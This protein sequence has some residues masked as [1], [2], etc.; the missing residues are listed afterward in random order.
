MAYKIC[1]VAQEN[2]VQVH[3]Y[4]VPHIN[5]EP[6]CLSTDLK[7]KI[8]DV[9]KMLSWIIERE[10]QCVPLLYKNQLCCSHRQGRDRLTQVTG[11]VAS[12]EGQ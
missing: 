2:T 3:G 12:N 1:E 7:N 5:T 11:V 8:Y 10:N 4:V 9:I 6:S